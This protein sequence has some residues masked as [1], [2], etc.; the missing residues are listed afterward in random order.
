MTF[1]NY[2]TLIRAVRKTYGFK[3]V[4]WKGVIIEGY[5]V[6]QC[7]DIWSFK[8]NSPR[9]LAT[10]VS[11]NSPYPKVCLAID[12]KRKTLTVH[13]LVCAAF[14]PGPKP[15]GVSKE[16]WNQTPNSVKA[17]VHHQYYVNHIDHNKL[18]H[19]PSNLEWVTAEEN[20]Q[21]RDAFIAAIL[22]AGVK[23]KQ[24]LKKAA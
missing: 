20:A 18:N 9:N 7:G 3:P 22:A 13:Q 10:C 1:T 11:G 15:A 21:K 24:T 23:K 12:G 16:D 17:H 5:F 4:I 14:H 19:H 8:G 2:E 6:S